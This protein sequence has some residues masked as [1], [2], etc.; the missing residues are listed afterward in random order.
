MLRP[1]GWLKLGALFGHWKME[2][3]AYLMASTK[4]TN[5]HPKDRVKFWGKIALLSAFKKGAS[6]NF[7]LESQK[8]EFE[9]LQAV[10]NSENIHWKNGEI[11]EIQK[12]TPLGTLSVSLKISRLVWLFGTPWGIRTP[13]LLVRSLISAITL[14]HVCS[15]CIPLNPLCYKAFRHSGSVGDWKIRVWKIWFWRK[16]LEEC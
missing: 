11:L 7:A 3:G 14:V 1:V 15:R 16:L 5:R 4:P 13:G 8:G 6:L 12:A 2:K 9:S 10:G